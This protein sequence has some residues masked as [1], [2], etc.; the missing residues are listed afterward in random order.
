MYYRKSGSYSYS[1]EGMLNYYKI[2]IERIINIANK[3]AEIGLICPSTLFGDVS[4]KKLRKWIIS[5][6]KLREISYYP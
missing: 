1:I 4:S 3:D 2:S 6:H 5:S